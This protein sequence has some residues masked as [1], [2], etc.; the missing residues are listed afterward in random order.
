[1]RLVL[2]TAFLLA[3]AAPAPAATVS[4]VDGTL[5]VIAGEG[6]EARPQFYFSADNGARYTVTQGIFQPGPGCELDAFKNAVCPARDDK[7]RL[8]LDFTAGR[9]QLVRGDPFP[10]SSSLVRGGALADLLALG[11]APDEIH[12]GGGNDQIDGLGGDDRLFGDA[13]DDHFTPGTGND[14]YDGGSGRD[15]LQY[16][17][18]DATRPQVD[19]VVYLDGQ[20]NDGP[21]GETDNVLE[22]EQVMTGDGEDVLVG[23]DAAEHLYAG[24]GVDIIKGGA[25]ADHLSPNGATTAHS[26]GQ[27]IRTPRVEKDTVDAG[28]GNDTIW[29]IELEGMRQVEDLVDDIACGS[30]KDTVI[31]GMRAARAL[32]RLGGD[33]EIACANTATFCR[34]RGIAPARMV[35]P[36]RLRGGRVEVSCPKARRGRRCSGTVDLRQGPRLFDSAKYR[37]RPGRRTR[38]R[39]DV[40]PGKYQAILTG[41]EGLI[42]V[43]DVVVP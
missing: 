42:A 15:S 5:S 30:G 27:V 36:E 12:G 2:T 31:T 8:D 3:I 19:T 32:R 16:D 13:G 17:H 20:A 28:P 18:P 10:Y 4:Y 11:D 23:S 41:A 39:L 21:K 24:G 43:R 9:A 40:P 35:G 29:D 38:V 14:V 34:E 25:G 33:C 22:M 26:N 6:E 1:M 37:L 7:A